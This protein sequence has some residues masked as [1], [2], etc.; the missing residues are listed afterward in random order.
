LSVSGKIRVLELIDDATVGGG[1]NHVLLLA[2]HL[3]RNVFDVTIACAGEGFLVEEARRMGIRVLP[4]GM[5]NRL[6]VRTLKHI[7]QLLRDSEYDVLHTHGG[8][9]GFWGRLGAVIAGKPPVRIHTYHGIH[10]LSGHHHTVKAWGQK[11]L[12]RIL[13]RFTDHTICVCES[14]FRKGLEAGLVTESKG[15]VIPCGIETQR[16]QRFD[17]R[18]RL[19]AELGVDD[20]SIVFGN[21]GRLHAQKGQRHLLEAFSV[22]REAYPHASLWIV[23]EG[24]LREELE[25]LARDLDIRS[26]VRFLGARADIPELLSAF[27][28]FV[29]SSLWEGQPLSVL[30]AMAAG[31]PI[32]ATDVNGIRDL[33][34]DGENALL[35]PAGSAGQLAAAM[36]RMIEERNLAPRLAAAARGALL[37][38][39]SVATMASRIGDLYRKDTSMR[40]SA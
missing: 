33:L 11:L 17:Q 26:S 7:T 35:V 6:S 31:K 12:E 38:M 19:R 4:I 37:G 39:F 10:Y 5:S 32:I 27:D 23:G 22:V 8:T 36:K 24:D 28:V 14:D 2:S 1:P 18:G 15:A 21:I 29:L 20:S 9:A 40:K 34:V 13:L 30:E 25:G 3:D 16:F